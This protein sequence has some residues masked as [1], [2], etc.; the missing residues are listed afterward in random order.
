MRLKDE[1]IQKPQWSQILSNIK[2]LLIN[3]KFFV[4]IIDFEI[5]VKS[6]NYSESVCIGYQYSTKSVAH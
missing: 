2:T 3:G 4:C 1:E 6:L 5:C